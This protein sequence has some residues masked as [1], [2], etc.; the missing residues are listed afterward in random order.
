LTAR[1]MDAA[2]RADAVVLVLGLTSGMEGE[3]SRLHIPGFDGGDRT[4]LDLPAPQEAL[5][6]EI[7]ALGKPTVLVLMNGSALAVDW[8][9][10]HVPAILD[11]WYPGEAG[12]TA[13]ADVLFGDY[14]PAGRLP[15]TFYRRLQDLP[16]FDSYD[17]AGRTYR[18]FTGTPLYPFGYG[19]SYTTF[20]YANLRTSAGAI[21]ASDTLAV[22]VDVT[23][24]GTRA[25][26]EVVQL[27][28]KHLD[29]AVPRARE[30]L[31]DYARVHLAPG[32]TRTVTLHLAARSLAYWNPNAQRWR[33]EAE[34]VELRV[35]ASS[36][37][38]RLTR[39]VRVGAGVFPP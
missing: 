26:D 29:S 22:R 33:V 30:D 35:G 39:I 18:F 31:R 34:P 23:N 5:M 20:R 10:E 25:G 38:I 17:M 28:V 13:V 6:R 27:Y 2:S 32:E 36:A 16:P 9:Q 37:D 15:I 4:S 14:D 11:A 3:E 21:G 1:A 12:G 7:V 24:T 8:A 19:L